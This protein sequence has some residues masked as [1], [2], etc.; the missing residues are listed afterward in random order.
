M[1]QPG[2]LLGRYEIE[3]LLGQ[4]GFGTVY[5]ARHKKLNQLYAIKELHDH[6]PRSVARF[7]KEAAMLAGLTHPALPKVND[8]FAENGRSY[9]VMEYIAG[10]D[11]S[12]YLQAQP[13]GRLDQTTAL[14]IIRPILEALAYLHSQQPPIIH[15]DI[16]DANI[17]ITAAQAVYLV[18]FGIAKAYDPHLP[19]TTMARSV[20]PG[21][22]PHE[23]YGN[24][25]TD[26]R[27]DIYALGATLY[28]ML[29]GEAP[30]EAT[31]R[32]RNDPLRPP[33]EL[34]PAVTPALERIILRMLAVWPD[35][36]YQHVAEVRHDFDQ[37]QAAVADRATIRVAP[38]PSP[39][40]PKPI[41]PPKPT[42]WFPLFGFALLVG[43][44]LIG[45]GSLLGKGNASGG[46][47]APSA[48][49]VPSSAVVAVARPSATAIP[50]TLTTVPTTSPTLTRTAIPP[51][52]TPTVAQPAWVPEMIAVPAGS[53]PMGSSD[54]QV[55]DVLRQD[56]S[57]TWVTNEQPQHS[58]NL[59]D[60]WIGKT[61][62]TNA[63]FRPF[64]D[65]DGYTNQAYWTAAGW[66]WRQAENITQPACWD[67]AAFNGATQP[68][69]C[70]SWFEAVAYCRWLSTQTGI[71]FRLPSEAEWEK[72]ARGSNGLIYPWGNTWD[73]SLVNSSE[74][75]LNK[76]MP[77]GSYPKGASPSGALDMAGNVWEWCATQWQKP[78][79]Y[80]IED[81]W[82]TAYLEATADSRVLRGGSSWDSGT[83]V[84]GAF[85]SLS[86][87]PR[88]RYDVGGLR[89]ASHS[90]VPG[91]DS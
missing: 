25:T 54:Q 89:V 68:V 14:R 1:L 66:A 86:N 63:Q 9:L 69:V 36:R 20:T 19:T 76:T 57:W 60:Y 11:L 21:Y 23:Q 91:S 64:V 10:Q 7:E 12:E 46:M 75:G 73:A 33:S 29:T 83:F 42:N 48:T 53:F 77:V 87:L 61:E 79:P 32:V 37:V 41:P 70:V 88:D 8:F 43:L 5:Q 84:R 59:P 67:D 90:L 18:D 49:A 28:S 51:T 71:E 65:G 52:A 22:S 6:D 39:P 2:D 30:D 40:S 58:L 34:N 38:P 82:Q 74:S 50:P 47:P 27:S 16:K 3:R 85:R 4:G 26:D 55:A 15:R 24:G 80:Q 13:N 17:R 44:V 31:A 62:V 35:Q 78:Y 81:E 56:A 45:M 72:A